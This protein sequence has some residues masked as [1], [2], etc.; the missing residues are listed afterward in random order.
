MARTLVIGYGNPGR[1]DDGLGPAL[2]NALETL[3]TAQVSVQSDYQLS[4][5]HAADLPGNDAVIFADAAVSGRS[6]F[7]LQRLLPCESASFTTHAM[8]AEAVLALAETSLGWRGEAYLF[9]IRGYAFNAFGEHLS[10][11]AREN[12]LA[13]TQWL[14]RVLRTGRVGDHVTGGPVRDSAQLCTGG[15]VCEMASM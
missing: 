7:F 8:R 12:L 5:E 11:P 15:G 13:A 2:V 9:G 10:A 14:A 3:V 1:L 4:A 6:P